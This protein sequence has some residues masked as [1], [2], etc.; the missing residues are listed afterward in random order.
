MNYTRNTTYH[1]EVIYATHNFKFVWY[2]FFK[3][4]KKKLCDRW[5]SSKSLTSKCDIT[6]VQCDIN[7]APKQNGESDYTELS[8]TSTSSNSENL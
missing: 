3:N 5:Y 1:T 7:I 8:G 6:W 4:E 2:K